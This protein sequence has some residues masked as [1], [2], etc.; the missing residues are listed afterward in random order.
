LP[1][2]LPLLPT[3]QWRRVNGVEIKQSDLD[4]AALGPRAALSNFSAEDRKKVLLQYL[5]ETESDRC[6][7]PRRQSR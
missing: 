2:L 3:I 1:S 7:R 5:I 4:Y 6:G